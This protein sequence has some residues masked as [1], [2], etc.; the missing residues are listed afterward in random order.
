[1]LVNFLSKRC[2]HQTLAL[3]EQQKS[4]IAK[5]IDVIKRLLTERCSIE[6]KEARV[7]SMENRLRLGQFVVQRRG[8]TLNEHWTNGSAFQEIGR[9]REAIVAEREEI[10]RLKEL[11]LKQRQSEFDRNSNIY[12]QCTEEYHQQQHEQLNSNLNES[13]QL[14]EKG[15]PFTTVGPG[16]TGYFGSDGFASFDSG[17]LCKVVKFVKPDRKS[18]EYTAQEYYQHDEMLKLRQNALKK[19]DADLQRELE[20]LVCQR[21]LHIREVK[22]IQNEDQ[23][24]YNNNPVLN[25]RYL[26]LT[27]LGKGGYSEVYKA[28]DLKEQ[29]Y[30]ACK[31]H[32]L[33]NNWSEVKKANY[34]RHALREYNI[35]MSMDSSLIVKLYDVFEVDANSFCTVMEYCDG[36]DLS[37]YLQQHKTIPER[38]A[39]SIIMQIASALKYLNEIKPPVIH[40]DIK[41]GNILLSEGNVCGAIKLTDFGLSKVMDI[42]NY[43]PDD[44][45]DLTSQGA[46]TL[47]YLP[48]ECFVIGDDPPKI[49]S[50][51]DVWSL[52]VVFYQCLYGKK[53]F[54]H[55]ISP[56]VIV[57]EKLILNATEVQFPNEPT[58][59]NEAKNFIRCCLTHC[60]EDR[61]NVFEL[62]QHEYIQPRVSKQQQQ[63]LD[64]SAKQQHN[65]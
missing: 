44:G 46:G 65:S 15:L 30:A 62:A 51:V 63:K 1:M 10:E 64:L 28:F 27:L 5:C 26:L 9:R 56:A 25:D 50:K 43:E 45:M 52:G 6:K 35:H 36:P 49:C 57:K 11:L 60:K 17:N 40:Y 39:R 14:S 4:H 31:I 59:S 29:R 55:N 21:G 24:I 53:P 16:S 34:F 61:M 48:P 58:V 33:N 3:I 47:W 22:R 12:Q 7:R 23:S 18:N 8:K 32:Q 13:S 54:A 37:H 20:S 19:E 38:Q 2:H 41:P 42:E